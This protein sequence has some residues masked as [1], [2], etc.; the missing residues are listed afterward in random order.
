MHAYI[1]SHTYVH[2]YVYAWKKKKVGQYRA[3]VAAFNGGDKR[4]EQPLCRRFC[5]A[6]PIIK[7]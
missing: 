7:K 4:A 5:F 6:P 3:D 1:H 2:A